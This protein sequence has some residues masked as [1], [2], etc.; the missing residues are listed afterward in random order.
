MSERKVLTTGRLDGL[1]ISP[2]VAEGTVTHL[3][4]TVDTLPGMR[5]T[6]EVDAARELLTALRL[7][8]DGGA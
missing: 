6:L 1:I 4:F 7:V 2:L 3:Q 8:L 5:L